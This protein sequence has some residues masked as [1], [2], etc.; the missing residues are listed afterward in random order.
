[1]IPLSLQDTRTLGNGVKIPAMGLGVWKMQSGADTQNAVTCALEAGYRAI[2]TASIYGNEEDVGKA[3][4]QSG[5]KRCDVFITT[6]VWYTAQGYE[7]TLKAFDESMRKM[8]LDYLDMYLIHHYMEP[9]LRD[10]WRAMEK[11]YEDKRIRAIGVSNFLAPQLDALLAFAD[12]KPVLNQ[13]E[14]HP[15]LQQRDTLYYDQSLGIQTQSWAPLA[16][17]QVLGEPIVSALAHKYGKTPAQ[18]V[19]RWGLQ[20]GVILIPKSSKPERIIK[21]AQIF[22][23]SLTDEEMARI[24]TLEK[25]MRF[26]SHPDDWAKWMV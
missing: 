18:I 8:K 1:M 7:S 16:K 20:L 17:G 22:D 2:D 12:V 14:M 5:L 10:T 9:R 4:H 19:L 23:F 25:N 13:I 11:L 21:N 26:G 3:I 24:D 6:K 15:Y